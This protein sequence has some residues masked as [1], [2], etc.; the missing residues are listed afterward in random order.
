MALEVLRRPTIPHRLEARADTPAHVVHQG[1]PL[2]PRRLAP[3]TGVDLGHTMESRPPVP[4]K[5][6]L[7]LPFPY[8]T[9]A[10]VPP[11]PVAPWTLPGYTFTRFVESGMARLAFGLCDATGERVAVKGARVGEDDDESHVL[12]E[13]IVEEAAVLRHAHTV[14]TGKFQ[15]GCHA[16]PKLLKTEG[17]G[18]HF[19]IVMNE[20]PGLPL[21]SDKL[22]QMPLRAL[23][24]T[25]RTILEALAH[26]HAAGVIHRD[27]KPANILVD[28]DCPSIAH[29]VDCGISVLKDKWHSGAD[30]ALAGTPEF[31]PPEGF[32]SAT[33][34]TP[35]YDIY[36][37]GMSL[38]DKILPG[39]F[40]CDPDNGALPCF[41]LDQLPKHWQDSQA[42]RVID[43]YTK[44]GNM[45]ATRA[46][47]FS[48]DLLSFLQ[49]MT[50]LNASERFQSTSEVTH[51]LA[52]LTTP[53]RNFRLSQ[54]G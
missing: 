1:V 5:L 21:D 45:S 38:L 49:K 19:Y 53:K 41:R 12:L 15:A 13:H 34:L 31:M 9:H 2:S 26:Y 35:A 17:H 48:A 33:T 7:T 11:A 39:K 47:E 42:R 36:S 50:A 28:E 46:A 20:V 51:A 29:L 23:F 40:V 52:R 43:E 30:R 44:Q 54:N 3:D 37:L 25:T 32:D 4:P 6:A 27:V 24:A 16:I 22:E 8:A 18:G 10:S 14:E